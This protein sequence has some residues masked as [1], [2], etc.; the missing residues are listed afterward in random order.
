MDPLRL[1]IFGRTVAVHAGSGVAGRVLRDELAHYPAAAPDSSPDLT[2]SFDAPHPRRVIAAN[3][4]AQVENEGGFTAR[5]TMAEVDY[6]WGAGRLRALGVRVNRPASGLWRQ[7]QRA[8]DM[9]FATREA[10]AGMIAHEL[11]LVPAMLLDPERLPIHASG[12]QSPDGGVLL[13]GGTG[14]VGK[15]SLCL[16]LGRTA[17]YRFLADDIAVLDARGRVFP[18]LAYPKVYG[19]NMVGHDDLRDSVLKGRGA[20]DRLHWHLHKARGLDKVRRRAA[21][22][23]L[24]G[25]VSEGGPLARYVVLMREARDEIAV[26]PVGADEAAELSVRVLQTEFAQFLTHLQ[27]HA[28]NRGLLGLEPFAT[29]EATISRWRDGLAQAL[30]TAE[31]A[32]ARIPIGMEHGAFRREMSAALT[33]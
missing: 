18:N 8:A 31:C 2:L 22:E 26:D 30:G 24:Y 27:W 3:P 13:L 19:Y 21:P 23:T 11:A 14:G 10:R 16:E 28:Y 1:H 7:A 32:V 4:S 12:L 33:A 25:P 9:Q 17:G 20:L 29:P 6:S 15:T 5:F